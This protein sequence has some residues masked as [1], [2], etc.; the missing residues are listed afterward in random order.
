MQ[1]VAPVAAEVGL[2]WRRDDE[3]EQLV[4]GQE[5]PHRIEAGAAVGTHPGADAEAHA[6]RVKQVAAGSGQLGSGRSEF[7]PRSDVPDPLRSE[8]ASQGPLSCVPAQPAAN[9]IP[10]AERT[11]ASSR[12]P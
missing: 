2:L 7:V 5:R 1:F 4:I 10:E 8:F 11:T 12:A 3:R 6:V 9:T